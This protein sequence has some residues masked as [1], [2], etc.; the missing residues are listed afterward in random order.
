M[1]E[2][3]ADRASSELD[4]DD[5]PIWGSRAIG[6]LVGLTPRQALYALEV[7]ILPGDRAGRKWVSTPKRLR[8]KFSGEAHG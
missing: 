7:G 6:E 2:I 4:P 1:A 8:A 5:V 3:H